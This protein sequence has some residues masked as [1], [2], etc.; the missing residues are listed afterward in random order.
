MSHDFMQPLIA[1]DVVPIMID[2]TGQ[3]LFILS[4]RKFEPYINQPALP[5][6]LLDGRET[7]HEAAHRAL[8]TKAGL[9]ANNLVNVGFFDHPTRDPRTKAI[10]I[11]FLAFVQVDDNTNFEIEYHNLDSNIED[12]TQYA[13]VPFD[14]MNIISTARTVLAKAFLNPLEPLVNQ[15]LFG[16]AHDI[17][18]S[19]MILQC[20]TSLG[21]HLSAS[22][23]ARKMR[24]VPYIQQTTAHINNGR[25][26]PPVAWVINNK[27]E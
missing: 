20:A 26:K 22:N 15:E 7:L 14:H 17:M 1:V 25:G 18:T 8:A 3:P 24:G 12:E 21:V 10:S 23:I 13:N 16:S 9:T 19:P 5:G 4:R 11:A 6:V 2:P 27:G